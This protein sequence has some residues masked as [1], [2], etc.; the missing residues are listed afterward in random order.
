M[1]F[2]VTFVTNALSNH[3]TV[4]W[5]TQPEWPKDAK[6]NVKQVQRAAN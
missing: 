5:V 1:D 2:S 3:G 6:D 4:A